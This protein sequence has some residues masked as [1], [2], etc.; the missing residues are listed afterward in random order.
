MFTTSY[1]IIL[2]LL[3]NPTWDTN[4]KH[5]LVYVA[6]SQDAGVIVNDCQMFKTACLIAEGKFTEAIAIG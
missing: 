3:L 6:F 2:I 1:R 4:T 5:I